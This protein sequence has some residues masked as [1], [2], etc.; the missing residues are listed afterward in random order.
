MGEG[1][2]VST[3]ICNFFI[4]VLR[5]FADRTTGQRVRQKGDDSTRPRCF[6]AIVQITSGPSTRTAN[7]VRVVC[8]ARRRR[9]FEEKTRKTFPCPL[10]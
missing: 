9:I 4:A 2:S 8:T 7:F 6:L 1:A 10:A 5:R 3:V